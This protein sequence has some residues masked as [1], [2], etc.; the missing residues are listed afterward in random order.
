MVNDEFWIGLAGN[1]EWWISNDEPGRRDVGGV[2]LPV[3]KWSGV[4]RDG[5]VGRM[6][7]CG[8]SAIAA[9]C[10]GPRSALHKPSQRAAKTIIFISRF[11]P[12]IIRNSKICTLKKDAVCCLSSFKRNLCFTKQ[13]EKPYGKVNGIW[14]IRKRGIN[15]ITL[16]NEELLFGGLDMFLRRNPQE[17]AC[18]GQQRWNA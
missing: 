5:M 4:W 14:N 15:Y 1:V 6:M 9:R 7:Q 12:R 2:V 11:H 8:A 16:S 18:H 13:G 17:C 3:M 10:V